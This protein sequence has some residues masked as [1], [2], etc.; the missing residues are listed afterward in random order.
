MLA[1]GSSPGRD[2]GVHL[3]YGSCIR[4]EQSIVT[5]KISGCVFWGG[6]KS[7]SAGFIP[8]PWST[9]PRDNSKGQFQVTR[10]SDKPSALLTE[11]SAG[12][13]EDFT[14]VQQEQPGMICNGSENC[15][16]KSKCE[17]E[18]NLSPYN[19]Q[20]HSF[21]SFFFL[22]FLSRMKYLFLC[23]VKCPSN[24]QID[25]FTQNLIW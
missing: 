1:D 8:R 3:D 5:N 20:Y 23:W 12:K 6:N 15:N 18:K 16:L 7:E 22:C 2:P 24:V 14:V 25:W 11:P 17:D 9:T 13:S 4:P 19:R 21:P 10:P